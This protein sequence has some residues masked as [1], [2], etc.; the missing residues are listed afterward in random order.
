MVDKKN[1]SMRHLGNPLYSN[2]YIESISEGI[3]ALDYYG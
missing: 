3:R 1:K 2:S